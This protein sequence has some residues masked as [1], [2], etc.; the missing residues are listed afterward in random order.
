MLILIAMMAGRFVSTL[1]GNTSPLS[2]G[3]LRCPV[4]ALVCPRHLIVEFVNLLKRPTFSLIDEEVDNRDA[5][6][7][8]C[9]PDEEDL[10]LQVS[11][12]WT[13]VD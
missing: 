6:E 9:K 2:E 10:G 8:A 4:H 1:A 5:D 7:A 11:V 13:I 12:T 3:S